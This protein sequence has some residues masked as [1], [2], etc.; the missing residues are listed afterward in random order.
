MHSYAM[1][2]NAQLVNGLCSNLSRVPRRNGR[3]LRPLGFWVRAMSMIIDQVALLCEYT[4][5][6][7]AG[8]STPGKGNSAD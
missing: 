1:W 2:Y 8:H 6:L 5:R 4:V 3:E 7:T